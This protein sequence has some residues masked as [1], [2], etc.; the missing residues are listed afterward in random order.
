MEGTQVER[1]QEDQ[2]RQ[3][4]RDKGEMGTIGVMRKRVRACGA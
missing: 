2:G 3:G 4:E 1:V